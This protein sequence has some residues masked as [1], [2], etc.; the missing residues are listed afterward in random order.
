M[1]GVGLS[2]PSALFLVLLVL[3][4]TNVI[5]WSWWIVVLPLFIP[6]I[7]LALVMGGMMLFAGVAYTIDYFVNKKR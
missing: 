2:L 3:K 1:K 6:F 7:I 5:D 4:L